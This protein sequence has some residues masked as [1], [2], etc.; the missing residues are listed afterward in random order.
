MGIH[1]HSNDM[2]HE[3]GKG[4]FA[5][6]M[7]DVVGKAGE[8]WCVKIIHGNGNKVGGGNNTN[9]NHSRTKQR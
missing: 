5:T 7:K 1:T 9:Q 3:L 6:I 4:S 8:W 2:A